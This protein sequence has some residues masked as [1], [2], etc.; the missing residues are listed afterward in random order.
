MSRC[1][2]N[3]QVFR[4]LERLLLMS[5]QTMDP[6][7]VIQWNGRPKRTPKPP[8]L[9]YWD[10]FVATDAWYVKELVADIPDEEMDAALEDSDFESDEGEEGEEE[11]SEGEEEDESYSEESVDEEDSIDEGGEESDD[12]STPS[13]ASST[14]TDEGTPSS[15]GV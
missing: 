15:K 11:E 3:H 4:R 13:H 14:P 5:V 7:L 10:E 12:P 1:Y 9:T 8:P 6:S 2:E